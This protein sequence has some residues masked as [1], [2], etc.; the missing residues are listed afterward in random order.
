[1]NKK[2]TKI[3]MGI[4][5]F[6]ILELSQVLSLSFEDNTADHA[7]LSA[8]NPS[9]ETNKGRYRTLSTVSMILERQNEGKTEILLQL[10]KNTGWMDGFWDLGACG[11]IDENETLTQATIRETKEEICIDV[12]PEDVEF[13]SLNHNNLG[14]K[15]IYY[16]FYIKIK[17]YTGKIKIGEPNK[18]AE[19]KWFDIKNL[20]ENIIPIRESALKDYKKGIVYNEIGWDNNV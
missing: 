5:C 9:A 11:H 10:R 18:C 8:N 15:G 6:L 20:P 14:K 13:V 2:L 16:C 17:N 3:V 1:M 7:S 12:L 4:S 19:L